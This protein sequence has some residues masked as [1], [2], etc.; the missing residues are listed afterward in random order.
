M[1]TARE[2]QVL[3]AIRE[4]VKT[5]LP[6]TMH[7]VREAIGLRSMSTVQAHLKSLQD[8]GYLRPRPKNRHRGIAL[9]ELA[10]KTAA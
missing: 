7:E 6:P 8:K 5:G 4:F 3:D 1:L 10:M 2:N 9:T